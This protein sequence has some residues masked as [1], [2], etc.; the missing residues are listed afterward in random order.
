M[1]KVSFETP[2]DNVMPPSQLVR[3]N[4]LPNWFVGDPR[5]PVEFREQQRKI[6]WDR[7]GM[8][9]TQAAYKRAL[10][11]RD[12]EIVAYC[13]STRRELSPEDGTPRTP[14]IAFRRKVNNNRAAK[15][16]I[17]R[18]LKRAKAA[19]RTTMREYGLTRRQQRSVCKSYIED[20]LE[21]DYED[22]IP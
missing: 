8:C 16:T 15:A 12:A 9:P 19:V 3:E 13:K 7:M 2:N 21:R 20:T 14:P 6:T 22:S 18:K 5:V 1:D 4:S 10:D 17:R 11:E